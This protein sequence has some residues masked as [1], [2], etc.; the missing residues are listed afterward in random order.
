MA[1]SG[2]LAEWTEG[3]TA[4]LSVAFFWKLPNA[5]QRAIWYRE[6]GYKV[7]AGGVGLFARKNYLAEV[8]TLQD[9]LIVGCERVS[10]F[11]LINYTEYGIIYL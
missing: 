10:F 4:F 7:R 9:G 6:Q 11:L 5:Y 1:W 3:D 8:A 2:G